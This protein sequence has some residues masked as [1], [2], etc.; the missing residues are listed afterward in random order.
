VDDDDPD[1]ADVP[2]PKRRGRKP[3]SLSRAARE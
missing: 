1:T 3:S 2:Q